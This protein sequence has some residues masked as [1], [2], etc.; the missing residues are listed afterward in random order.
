[1]DEYEESIVN[2][3]TVVD[4][5]PSE[6]EESEEIES[7][8]LD[9][10]NG[11]YFQRKRRS[12]N[13]AQETGSIEVDYTVIWA[14]TQ[15]MLENPEGFTDA[16]TQGQM[17]LIDI[18]IGDGQVD[19]EFIIEELDDN[20]EQF[21]EIIP[22]YTPEEVCEELAQCEP[23]FECDQADDEDEE[24]V[25][26]TVCLSLCAPRLSACSRSNERCALAPDLGG[27]LCSCNDDYLDMFDSCISQWWVIGFS[28]GLF[29]I[30]VAVIVV[31]IICCMRR[32][33]N[34]RVRKESDY[35][36]K[37]S[38]TSDNDPYRPSGIFNEIE[39]EDRG[40]QA[41]YFDNT[42]DKRRPQSTS[43]WDRPT[44][45]PTYDNTASD[46]S[47]VYAVSLAAEFNDFE[48][49]LKNVD[50]ANPFKIQRPNIRNESPYESL[51]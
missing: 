44:I 46:E 35:F 13:R 39:E 7:N 14:V 5:V 31:V 22:V 32:R 23:G 38:E 30:V 24:A 42:E 37:L 51:R 41:L 10:S 6:E 8:S 45:S 4:G 49:Q 25:L 36:D 33:K 43:V 34:S 19:G 20:I 26:G 1:V 50:T 40:Q 15:E 28:I 47:Q 48:P 21:E 17:N 2:T 29:L 18:P 11:K 12:T 9:R 3:I 16:V 27:V